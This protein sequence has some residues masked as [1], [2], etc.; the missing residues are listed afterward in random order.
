MCGPARSSGS[1]A[2]AGEETELVGIFRMELA[3]SQTKSVAT[4]ALEVFQSDRSGR[5]PDREPK[6]LSDIRAQPGEAPSRPR[7]LRSRHRSSHP[8][9]LDALPR[10][11]RD[12]RPTLLHADLLLPRGDEALLARLQRPPQSLQTN[13]RP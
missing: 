12:R 1:S 3:L 6:F 13:Q 9:F 4:T 2:L 5:E 10:L 11:L 8:G 7:L